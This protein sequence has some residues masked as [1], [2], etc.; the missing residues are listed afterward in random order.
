MSSNG[1]E[2]VGERRAWQARASGESGLLLRWTEL[3]GVELLRADFRNHA[4]VPHWHDSYM[5]GTSAHGAERLRHAGAERLVRPGTLTTLNPGELHDGEA[6]D[7]ETGWHFRVLYCSEE[8]VAGVARAR[9]LTSGAEFRFEQVI[10]DHTLA[11]HVF[12]AMH[13]GLESA[14]SRLELE[15][16]FSVGMARILDY[17]GTKGECNPEPEMCRGPL[18]R[19][20][21]Y[22]HEAWARPVSLEA[23][24]EVAGLS[25]YHLLRTF[26][27]QF[28]LPPHAYQMQ[29][30]VVRAKELLFNGIAA[31]DVALEVGFYD[32]AHLTNALRRYTGV[33]PGRVWQHGLVQA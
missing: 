10:L 22:L 9:G 5:I 24:A 20:R 2:G 7:P 16:H 14:I 18:G 33:T 19:A 21:D 28:G 23:L 6:E 3:P 11:A 32:Q 8:S 12:L 13:R 31:K 25:R 26:R 15:S 29:L 27:K 4:F 30:R 1:S 17:A